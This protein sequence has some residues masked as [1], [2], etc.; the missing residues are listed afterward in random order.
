MKNKANILIIN[1][2]PEKSVSVEKLLDPYHF[3][4]FHTQFD[5][6]SLKLIPSLDF[7]MVI[8][9]V[10]TSE[11]D[12]LNSLRFLH[13]TKMFREVPVIFISDIVPR[14]RFFIKLVKSGTVDFLYRPIIPGIL[15]GKATF[16]H[17]HYHQKVKNV[18][19]L[20]E[21]EKIN[22]A[23]TEAKYKAEQASFT[24]TMFLAN[25]SHEIR[26]PLNGI[27]GMANVLAETDL[28]KEQR[29]FLNLV[30]VSGENLLMIINDILDFSKIEAG[31][32]S[33]EEVIFDLPSEIE[34]V[35]TLMQL[36]ALDK[37]LE[38]RYVIDNQIN[39]YVIGDPLRLKQILINLINN[40]IKFTETGSI[41]LK[42]DLTMN[43]FDQQNLKFS[44]I[45]TGIGINEESKYKLFEEFSQA[46]NS[47]TRK[48]GGT[49]LG[50]AICRSLI[51]LLQGRIGME[52]DLGKGSTFWIEIPYRPSFKNP[53][54][55][56][57]IIESPGQIN[58]KILVAEDNSINQ[59][60]AIH[61]LD[62]LGYQCDLAKNGKQ[63]VELHLRNKYD[64]IFMDI[65]MPELDGLEAS[66][67]I[68][69]YENENQPL[70]P[71]II[72]A[73]TANA[74]KEDKLNCLQAGMN[75]HMSKPFRPEELKKILRLVSQMVNKI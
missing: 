66:K 69:K 53:G 60:V 47:I 3:K 2:T 30:Q 62:Q 75:F 40:A 26:T 57:M 55:D 1:D 59:K 48:F 14:S 35:I 21:K 43:L 10:Q 71:V 72:V 70:R 24:K 22:L 74:F 39:K 42:V 46:D 27:L 25:M 49:G 16:Y 34:T 12:G 33:I 50:L 51:K 52:S 58:L 28:S 38:L 11:K 67:F 37:H 54:Q 9:D 7:V 19:L 45:D 65:Q 17:N 36:N 44:V 32:I 13:N 63:A 8:I 56:E 23:L 6:E 20:K 18:Q 15:I 61:S 64:V 5:N 31:Q 73:A 29:S 4:Y 41:S 68:R